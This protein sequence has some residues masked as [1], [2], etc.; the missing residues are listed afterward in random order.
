MVELKRNLRTKYVSNFSLFAVAMD[1]SKAP[2]D[3]VL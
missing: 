2:L 1:C 3:I